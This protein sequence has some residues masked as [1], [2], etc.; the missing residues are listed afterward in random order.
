MKGQLPASL[1]A[2][3]L[4]AASAAC[5]APAVTG[6]PAVTLQ[7]V[8]DGLDLPVGVT[9]AGDGSGR[10]FVLEQRGK[11]RVVDGGQ[12]LATPFLD[13]SGQV[14][15][16]G[17]RGLLGLAFHPGYAQEGR[18][19]VDYTD[20]AGNTVVAAYRVSPGDPNRAEPASREVLFTVAQP[21]ANHNGGQLAFGPDGDLYV[22]LGDGGSGGDPLRNGQNLSTLLGKILRIDIDH[23]DPGRAY[24]IPADNPFAGTA[25]ARGEIWAYGLRNPWRFS[26]DRGSG[27]LFVGDVGQDAWEEIDLQLSTSAGGENYGW[28]RTEGNHCYPPSSGS[29][30]FDGVSRPILEYSHAQGCSV[31]GGFRYR[32]LASPA[33]AGMYL[34]A[35]Y[36]SGTLWGAQPGAGGWTTT[37][38]LATGES[39]SSFGE[40]D[41]GEVYLVEYAPGGGRVERIV[42]TGPPPA[43]CRAGSL[44]L[45][46]GDR[47]EVQASFHTPQ[48]GTGDGQPQRLTADSGTFW[49]FNVDNVELLVKVLDACGPFGRFWVFSAGLTN[50]E[51]ELDVRD[52]QTGAAKIYRNPLGRAYPPLLDTAAFATCP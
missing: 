41:D 12:L 47:F 3:A 29:C 42:A 49:F 10:L 16:C 38:L 27:D 36:C 15:C 25:G 23:R 52:S 21:F 46:A 1:L 30:S 35:D 14:S 19:F 24:A 8:V 31:T 26:F 37:A 45:G 5:G 39:V 18:F 28:N 44:C 32:G 48:G 2:A 4:L 22:G 33:L 20:A 50:V 13:L 51:V 34:Y 11:I 7:T 40:G 43:P 6:D 17:E 9:H